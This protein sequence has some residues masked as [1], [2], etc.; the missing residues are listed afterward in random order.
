[1]NVAQWVDLGGG[2]PAGFL[3]R[4]NIWVEESLANASSKAFVQFLMETA[5][6]RTDPGQV[7]VIVFDD[8]LTGL[9]APFQD[10][11][12]GG[13]RILR[14]VNRPPD[15]A[16]CLRYLREHIQGV[17]NVVQGRSPSLLDFRESTGFPVEGF[18][19]VVIATDFGV[20]D[21]SLQN[22]IIALAKVG[23][24]HG[25]TFLVHSMMLDVNPYA[26]GL[27]TCWRIQDSRVLD[28]RDRPL[29]SFPGVDPEHLIATAN[30]VRERMSARTAETVLFLEIEKDEQTW[31]Q[32]S[33]EGI[34]FSVGRY[35]MAP[36]TI[37]LGDEVNQRHNVLI[38]G[39]VGQ[40]KSNL[41]SVM[42]HSLCHRYSPD[43]LQLVMLDFKEGVTLQR[44]AE[45]QDGT[46]LPHARVLGLEA[47]REFAVAVLEHLFAIY[48]E[49]MSAFKASGVQSLREYRQVHRHRPMPRIVFVV[50]EFQMMFAERDRVSDVCAELLQRA[51]RL[52]RAA[53]IHVVL[54]SQTI[55]GNTSLVGSASEGLFGQVPIRL[56][57]KNSLAE[58]RATLGMSNDAAAHLR[59]REAIVNLDYGEPSMNRKTAIAFADEEVLAPLRRQWWQA[60]PGTDKPYV[61]NGDAPRCLED[62]VDAVAA[63]SRT[64]AQPR[65]F[66]GRLIGVE[67]DSLTASMRREAGRNVAVVG[68]ADATIPLASAVVSLLAQS[69]SRGA[70]VVLLDLLGA[71]RGWEATRGAFA[72][73]VK[74]LNGTLRV[75][76]AVGAQ[77]ELGALLERADGGA[78][79]DRPT[80]VLGLGMER[81][82]SCASF[83]RLCALG[84]GVGIH[85][86][87]WWLKLNAFQN[88]AGYD[89]ASLFDVKAGYG[90]DSQSAR[91]FLDDPLLDWVPRDNR[92]VVWDSA[93]MPFP[94]KVIPYTRFAGGGDS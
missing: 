14:V 40:G 65:A 92:M 41:I 54:A 75:V 64:T 32:S 79:S 38:T 82:R 6:E 62:D 2:T 69:S 27:F 19:L 25:V 30:R 77:D 81:M 71:D 45:Q 56:A 63:G 33:A 37:T 24:A 10:V 94:R 20:L 88:L 53:G 8:A 49:R 57:L 47:D 78:V 36:I 46:F 34:T 60:R 23:P 22:E 70:E 48:K 44:L 28:S 52:F 12:N 91:R 76:D 55:G 39:A 83:E 1:M 66:L 18:K 26:L 93:E 72:R 85:L 11:N 84:P 29:G 59:S 16:Q 67:G 50:D 35:G 80:Y 4:S 51:V 90:L 7:E 87:C 61:F 43:E 58:S 89:G 74:E 86:L 3:G 5:L 13:E 21:D 9:A 68:A 73:R 15:L 17:A 42:V 31:A